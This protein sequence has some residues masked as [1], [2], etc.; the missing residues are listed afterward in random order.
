METGGNPGMD[1]V[2]AGVTLSCWDQPALIT[3]VHDMNDA[4]LTF[5]QWEPDH[6]QF[7]Y[8]GDTRKAEDD[9]SEGLEY[10][11]DGQHGKAARKFRS[12]LRR[13]PEHIGALHHLG[14]ALKEQGKDLDAWAF[15][16]MAVSVA[17]AKIPGDFDWEG[18]VIS[19]YEGDNRP[20]MRACLQL[21]LELMDRGFCDR[22]CTYLEHLLAVWANDN[23]GVRYVVP[24]CY[25]RMEAWDKVLSHATAN[26]EDDSPYI[27][28]A[29]PLALTKSGRDEE[30]REAM[31]Q[32]IKRRP[33]VAQELLKTEHEPPPS[34]IPWGESPGGE[35]EAYNYWQRMGPFW[36]SDRKALDMLQ[37][38]A[39]Q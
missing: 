33:K 37:T 12:A 24:E 13:F 34:M 23:L 26:P 16:E 21:A 19:W 15:F 5:E 35:D 2:G 30:A 22:A 3:G 10:L 27:L 9:F 38:V 8:R 11:E 32:A 17:K 4:K 25:L 31:K 39:G 20:Y 14:C 29:V 18:V 7:S 36:A 6:W 1:G 28:Y